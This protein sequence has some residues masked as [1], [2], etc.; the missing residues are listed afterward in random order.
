LKAL[1]IDLLNLLIASRAPIS[2]DDNEYSLQAYDN[3]SP[4]DL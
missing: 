3:M 4:S 1:F 2:E